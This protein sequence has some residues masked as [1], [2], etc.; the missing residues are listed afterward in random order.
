MRF[1][2]TTAYKKMRRCARVAEK[3]I[4][5]KKQDW[6]DGQDERKDKRLAPIEPSCESIKSSSSCSILK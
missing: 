4:R 6:L 2:E 3:E 5:Q 1:F